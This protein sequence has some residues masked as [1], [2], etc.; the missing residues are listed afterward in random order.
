LEDQ[1]LHVKYR[2]TTLEEFLGHDALKKSLG[3]AL[4]STNPPRA[5]LLLGPR[6]CGKTSLARIIGRNVDCS[7]WSLVEADAAS[8]RGIDDVK[9][10][11][12]NVHLRPLYGEA[13]VHII[14]EAHGL[15]AFAQDALL[16]ILEDC[17]PHA[18]F[19]LCSTDPQKIK[20]TVRSRCAEYS[21]APLGNPLM[22]DLLYDVC[23]KEKYPESVPTDEI[24]EMIVESAEGI[25][26]DAL[27]YLSM[28]QGF[29]D[30]DEARKVI[31]K[32]IG[33]EETGFIQLARALLNRRSVIDI[34]KFYKNIPERDPVKIRIGLANYMR[35]VLLNAKNERQAQSAAS[36]LQHLVRPVTY[37]IA[38]AELVLDLYL[39]VRDK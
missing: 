16:K 27:I 5:F 28:L 9:N 38:E 8:N 25:P 33:E 21:V 17:P 3:D 7:K 37:D 13:K 23:E 26:R 20:K 24:L 14:D 22:L 35:S 31:R 39:A 12:E 4:G 6:G 30:A 1:P 34:L 18:H 19:I 2:P 10:L 15:T 11:L 36:L 32:S 29:T